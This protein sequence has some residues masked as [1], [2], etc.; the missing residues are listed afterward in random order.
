MS[1]EGMGLSQWHLRCPR[2]IA[3]VI[4]KAQEVFGEQGVVWLVGHNQVL[5]AAPLDVIAQGKTDKVLTLL[6]QIEYGVYV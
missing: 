6:G 4:G 3:A 1:S 2:E 5:Q